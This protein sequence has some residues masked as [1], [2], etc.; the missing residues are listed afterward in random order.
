[1]YH[2][3]IMSK[4][5]RKNKKNNPNAGKVKAAIGF[6]FKTLF[7]NEG[8]IEGGVKKPWY[9]AVIIGLIAVLVSV[10]PMFVQRAR[11]NG[12]D[13]INGQYNYGFD[14][15]SEKFVAALEDKNFSLIVKDGDSGKTLD[16]KL[17]DWDAA[18]TETDA[19]GF[20]RFKHINNDNAIDFEAYFIPNK[21]TNEVL[22]HIGSNIPNDDGTFSARKSSFLVFSPT[23]MVVSLYKP[24]TTSAV[25]SIRGDYALFDS[26]YDFRSIGKVT[27]N[28]AEVTSKTYTAENY[29][30][31]RELVFENWK[32]FFDK[33]YYNNKVTM[34]WSTTGILLGVNAAIIVFMGLMVFLLTRG[35]QNNWKGIITFW[36]AQKT[37]YWASLA[38]AI[39]S[40][41]LGFLMSSFAQI[42]F[43]LLMGMRS[44]WMVM[45]Q[46][47]P[48]NPIPPTIVE[49][50]KK[51]SKIFN[52][53]SK[54]VKN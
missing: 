48:T 43:V 11:V 30:K 50:V 40:V 18:F 2:S 33:S 19:R 47:A 1:M 16:V 41:A 35:K 52:A 12:R 22:G 17:E 21:I 9:P 24:G 45:R 13:F 20:H 5:K 54:P 26:G 25:S 37:S 8:A 29:G 39:L 28:G 4:D 27:I 42:A 32:T 44:M 51:E 6:F 46:L 31:Y 7:K 38:P 10:I 49:P 34:L 14:V 53:K 3:S 36:N 23:E 15:A